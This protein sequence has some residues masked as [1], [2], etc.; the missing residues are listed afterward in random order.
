[1]A[2]RR[3]STPSSQIP[4]SARRVELWFG[5]SNRWGCTAY[6]SNEGANYAFDVEANDDRAVLSFDGDGSESQSGDDH[7]RTARSSCT[8]IRSRLEQCAASS[9]GYAKWSI[10]G[11]YKVD[12][13]TAKQ[14]LV[15]RANGADLEAADPA[16][17]VPRGSD[18]EVWFS[19]TSVHGCT[20]ADT[21]SGG[22][23]HYAIN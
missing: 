5:S 3:P 8:T 19:S 23:Y 4:S 17:T 20:E 7:R 10:T 22:N 21:N 6:D 14:V 12:G 13:G 11:F 9:G 2:R 18:L 1:M 16:I 15:T